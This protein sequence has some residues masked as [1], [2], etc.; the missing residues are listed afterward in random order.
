MN[1]VLHPYLD[2]FVIAYLDDIIVY[3][4]NEEENLEN[5]VA[6]LRLLR[7]H[8]LYTKLNKCSFFQSKIH[9]LGQVVS[10]KWIAVDPKNIK[11]IME[12]PTLRNVD[13][14]KSFMRLAG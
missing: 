7:E 13:E 9:Y 3:S 12:W 5:L 6:L 10:T 11:V 8:Q 1:N 14:V 4:N 2:N